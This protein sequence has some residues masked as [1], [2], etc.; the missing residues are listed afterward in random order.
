MLT[1]VLLTHAAI[2]RPK[3]G[4]WEYLLFQVGHGWLKPSFL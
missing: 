4:D 3:N 2:G 1:G